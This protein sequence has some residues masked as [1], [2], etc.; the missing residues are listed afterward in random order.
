MEQGK[1]AAAKTTVG[2]LAL[3]TLFC[4]TFYGGRMSTTV[5]FIS[6]AHSVIDAA[7]SCDEGMFIGGCTDCSSCPTHDATSI[8]AAGGDPQGAIGQGMVGLYYKYP[9]GGCSYFKDTLCSY[10]DAIGNC[11]ED[12]VTCTNATDSICN[13]CEEGFWDVDCKEC[14]DCGKT[15]FQVSA[16]EQSADTVCEK[17][18]DCPADSFITAGCTTSG[19]NV[20]CDPCTVCNSTQYLVEA[21]QVDADTRCAPCTICGE[22]DFIKEPCGFDV[23]TVCQE[24]GQCEYAYD[25]AGNIVEALEYISEEC[26]A[27]TD[28]V[29]AECTHPQAY[30]WRVSNCSGDQDA[31]YADCTVCELGTYEDLP[32]QFIQDTTCPE[33]TN[34]PH[35][36]DGS[37]RCHNDIDQHCEACEEGYI[38]L[39]CCYERSF[40][41]CNTE[42]TR[43]RSAL[44]GGFSGN[45]DAE[46][47]YFCM[48]MCDELPDCAAFEIM[49]GGADDTATGPNSLTTPDA[50]C[51][52][53]TDFTPEG[54]PG[55]DPS[56][57]CYTNVC[58]K[59]I[60]L[61]GFDETRSMGHAK[62]T[63]DKGFDTNQGNA[64]VGMPT[65]RR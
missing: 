56:K 14:T 3:V 39:R 61:A 16:C 48:D 17:C 51:Y 18:G 10:C 1:V 11:M 53:K 49:D 7:L 24:C 43:E 55:T 34:V 37:V 21:C 46:F 32:C 45:S 9:T 50:T 12:F 19:G 62:D 27:T 6:D 5:G 58:G 41:D 33:C 59:V 42:T 35:C 40:T 20:E 44:R 47:I 26:T 2:A 64:G 38:G 13:K 28:T 4:A 60:Q 63:R 36:Q 23:D 22:N 25:G 30:K 29:C 8:S 54:E 15:H 57:D 65:E 52:F 31:V